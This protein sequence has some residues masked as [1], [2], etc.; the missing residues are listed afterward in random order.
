MYNRLAG[1]VEARNTEKRIGMTEEERR[2]S[3]ASETEDVAREDQ[4]LLRQ[5][6]DGIDIMRSEAAATPLKGDEAL[7][8]LDS[9][10]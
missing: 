6:L 8:A 7:T 9:I 3:L 2:A 4:I 1:E 10:F 5:G